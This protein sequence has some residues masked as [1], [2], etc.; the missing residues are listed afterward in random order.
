VTFI[1]PIL[2][3]ETRTA[4]V[5]IELA[6]HDGLLKP[7]MFASVAL[8]AER[9]T[10][11]LAVPDSA[12]LDTGTRQLVL[13]DRGGGVFE[14]REIRVGARGDGYVEVVA[15]LETGELVVVNGN[16][17]IDAESN[18][19][20]AVGGAAGGGTASAPV[21]APHPTAEPEH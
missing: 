11:C 2:Q 17:L 9:G 14:P 12:I 13:V 8:R 21:A 18:L 3:A 5:R 10:A 16:F 19:R 7:A 15:G 4:Q 6:N 1:S 20:A